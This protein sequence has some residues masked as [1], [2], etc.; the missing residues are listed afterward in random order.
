MDCLEFIKNSEKT[1]HDFSI[2]SE[3]GLSIYLGSSI[4]IL[5]PRVTGHTVEDVFK[6]PKSNCGVKWDSNGYITLSQSASYDLFKP[7]IDTIISDVKQFL[8]DHDEDKYELI[9]L[10]GEFCRYKSFQEAMQKE[11]EPKIR[12]FMPTDPHLAVVQGAVLFGHQ[13]RQS[14]DD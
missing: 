14:L 1:L 8:S 5:Y 3:R 9:C 2:K 10:V 13:A 4:Y 6:A 11:F 12:V 7:D